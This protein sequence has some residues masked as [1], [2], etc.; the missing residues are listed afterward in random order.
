MNKVQKYQEKIKS[1]QFNEKKFQ[2]TRTVGKAKLG[3]NLEKFQEPSQFQAM[4]TKI[5]KEIK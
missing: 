3:S 5:Q 4:H 2:S 1:N